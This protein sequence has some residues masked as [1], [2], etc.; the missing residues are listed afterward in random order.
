ME[1]ERKIEKLLRAC[2]KRRRA[3]AGDAFALPPATRRR[4]QAEVDQQFTDPAAE[5]SVSLWQ[6]FRQQWAVLAG[7]ALLIFLGAALFLPVLSKAKMKSQSISAMVILRQ[8]GAA[9]QIAAVDHSGRLPAT[10]D[11]L[12]NNHLLSEKALTDPVSGKRFEF[13][14][15]GEK[16]DA[17]ASNAVLAYS[18]EDKTGRTVLLADGSVRM[19]SRKQFDDL[20]QRTF[21]ASAAPAEIASA[22]REVAGESRLAGKASQPRQVPSAA[23]GVSSGTLAL[24]GGNRLGDGD[25]AGGGNDFALEKKE[26]SAAMVAP[27]AAQAKQLFK[28][29]G[30]ANPSQADMNGNSQLFRNAAA[31]VVPVLVAFELQQNGSRLAIIDAD[32]SVYQGSLQPEN[33]ASPNPVPVVAPPADALKQ[34]SATAQNVTV[35]TANNYLFRVAGQNRTLKQNVVF[36]GNLL[37]F[38]GADSNSPIGS[39]LNKAIQANQVAAGAPNQML[40]SN[41]RIIGTLTIDSTNQVEINAVPVNP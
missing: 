41:S 17:L 12:T 32:G 2:A 23:P 37:S 11:E 15:G 21:K 36:A 16:L 33:Q 13:A 27:A 5:E 29:E 28:D 26:R 14:A 38:E 24:N 25:G 39:N 10:L 18:P 3:E 30:R 4:L 20:E 34:T 7:F 9:A 1:P 8:I 19:M 22:R 6:L 40:N 31:N 35:A